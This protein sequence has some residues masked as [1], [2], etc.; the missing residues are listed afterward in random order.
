MK[1]IPIMVTEV[2]ETHVLVGIVGVIIGAAISRFYF[3][4]RIQQK[5][6]GQA[7]EF[8][9]IEKQIIQ[10]ESMMKK[11]NGLVDEIKACSDEI[12][13]RIEL[14][15]DIEERT[16]PSERKEDRPPITN[17]LDQLTELRVVGKDQSQ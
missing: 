14:I 5:N 3:Q 10:L 2:I 11:H 17:G 12:S 9:V 15:R 16:G 13:E 6:I 7:I 8:A 1:F 4:R